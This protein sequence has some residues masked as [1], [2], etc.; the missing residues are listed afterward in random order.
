MEGS[1]ETPHLREISF[2]SLPCELSEKIKKYNI[3]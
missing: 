3:L 1:G 2:D